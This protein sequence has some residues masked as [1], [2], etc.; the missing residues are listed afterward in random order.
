MFA[1]PLNLAIGMFVHPFRD[2]IVL[3]YDKYRVP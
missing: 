1:V 3:A 2:R